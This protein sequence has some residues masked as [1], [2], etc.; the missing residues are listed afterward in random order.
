MGLKN[1]RINFNI[2]IAVVILVVALVVF[3]I[4]AQKSC[5]TI[6][7]Y[8]KLKGEYDAYKKTTEVSQAKSVQAIAQ[9]DKEIGQLTDKNKVLEKSVTEKTG[10]IQIKGKE[11]GDLE[12]ALKTTTDKDQIIVIL[13]QEVIKWSEKFSIAEGIIQDKDAIIANW[14]K[15][16]NAQVVISDE[17]KKQYE[18]EHTLR[19]LAEDIN[20]KSENKLKIA[21]LGSNIKTLILIGAVGYVGYDKFVRKK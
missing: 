11:I 17:W 5:V 3:G 16:F 19:L 7:K 4:I 1:L 13:K 15:K 20:K 8:S 6:D 10:A 14:E 2:N 12:E 18:G 9:K 21:K